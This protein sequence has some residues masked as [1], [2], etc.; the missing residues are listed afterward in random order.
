MGGFKEGREKGPENILHSRK[1][2]VVFAWTH[3]GRRNT[4][5]RESTKIVCACGKEAIQEIKHI[6]KQITRPEKYK[7]R[8]PKRRKEKS[9]EIE[10]K[11]EKEILRSLP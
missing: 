8:K 3:F 10:K 11:G 7:K 4:R 1:D 2:T 5:C 6:D 9:K